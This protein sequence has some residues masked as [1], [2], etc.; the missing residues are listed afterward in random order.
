MT[1]S[2]LISFGAGTLTLISGLVFTLVISRGLSVTEYGTWG[3]IWGL[4]AYV[5][6]LD[7]TVSYW[8]TREAAQGKKSAKTAFFTSGGL[9]VIA[10]IAYI[11][12]A[13]TYAP[14]GDAELGALVFAVILVPSEIIKRLF[15]ALGL[16]HRPHAV[17]YG[18]L[19]G[20]LVKT[21]FAFTLVFSYGMGI[22]GVLLAALFGTIANIVLLVGYLRN[23]LGGKL[24][25]S[26]IKKWTRLFWIPTWRQL[27]PLLTRS[28]VVVFSI[29]TGSVVGVAYWTAARAIAT[30]TAHAARINAPLYPKLLGGGSHEELQENLRL[31]LYVTFALGAIVIA[32]SAPALWALNPIYEAAAPASVILVGLVSMRMLA[33]VF[34]RAITGVE[35]VDTITTRTGAYLKSKLFTIPALLVA[36][37]S[38]YLVALAVMLLVFVQLEISV[39]ELV[40]YWAALALVIQAPHFVHFCILCKREFNPHLDVLR[41]AKY[42]VCALITF[43]ITYGISEYMLVRDGGALE[44]APKVVGV[45]SIGI[46]SY[47]GLTYA[48]DSKTRRLASLVIKEIRGNRS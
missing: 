43:G 47:I 45:A 1:Y 23:E 29:V 44:F 9:S 48:A 14:S 34:A 36:Q 12:I 19:I 20:E 5:L 42:A 15:A 21:A 33:N 27:V 40:V 13:Y 18:L 39:P 37:R 38:A 46:A 26:Y 2:G 7:P 4:L 41:I 11:V 22:E 16:A 25:S 3:V 10:I 32:L 24:D 28:D 31:V 30:V 8:A 35:D 17:E 6:L